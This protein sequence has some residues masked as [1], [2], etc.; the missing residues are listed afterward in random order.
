MAAIVI[1]VGL[2]GVVVEGH[3]GIARVA[4]ALAFTFFVPGRAVVSNWPR[5][6][7]WSQFGMS[8]VLSLA[9]VTLLATTVLWVGAWH[10]VSLFYVEAG[11]SAVALVAGMLRRHRGIA[12][13]TS[14]D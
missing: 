1:A 12:A 2:I 11:L 4:L 13:E 6:A 10:P 14:S 3:A 9:I 5:L 7:Y 8:M